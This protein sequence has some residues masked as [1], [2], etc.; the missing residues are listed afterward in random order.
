MHAHNHIK[1]GNAYTRAHSDTYLNIDIHNTRTDA[2]IY[3]IIHMKT[4]NCV[5]IRMHAHTHEQAYIHVHIRAY[6]PIC[7]HTGPRAYINIRLAVWIYV[8]ICNH[9]IT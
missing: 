8:H 2:C 6:T 3:G 4:Y 9:T 7:L 5:H 1:R